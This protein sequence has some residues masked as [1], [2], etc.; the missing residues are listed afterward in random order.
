MKM[1]A[2]LILKVQLNIHIGQRIILTSWILV[3]V[4]RKKEDRQ[5]SKNMT[6]A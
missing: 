2:A 4:V 5:E 1:F 3:L 6:P